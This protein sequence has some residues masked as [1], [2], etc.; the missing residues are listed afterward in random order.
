MDK[1]AVRNQE[2]IELWQ[3]PQEVK[4]IVAPKLNNTEFGFFMALSKALG[5]NP[6]KREIWAI[7]YGTEPA[8]VFCGRDF[9]RRKAQEQK[10]YKGHVVECI[11]KN[12]EFA[13]KREINLSTGETKIS[14]VIHNYGIDRGEL[15]GAY[16]IVFREGKSPTYVN[17]PLAEFQ[18][19]KKGGEITTMWKTKAETQIKKVAES[20]TLRM[21]YQDVFGGTYDESEKW[22]GKTIDI[23]PGE[24]EPAYKT[25]KLAT[26]P[27][28]DL[29]RNIVKS[30]VF[31]EQERDTI[32]AKAADALLTVKEFEKGKKWLQDTS[33][34]RKD[35][36]KAAKAE[37]APAQEFGEEEA[38]KGLQV[39][40]AQYGEQS[41]EAMDYASA[42]QAEDYDIL[43]K[44]VGAAEN[45]AKN[46]PEKMA[47]SEIPNGGIPA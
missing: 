1:L 42:W 30:H 33:K 25:E 20:L 2:V 35:A 24:K 19:R 10:D 18:Q 8:Q 39:V 40:S 9:Y 5:A 32:L 34:Y 22:E 3:N 31:T 13:V 37:A 45:A 7:K 29:M 27:Q 11:R 46:M 26:G 6:F 23:S 17:V 15:L 38:M 28:K 16:C 14:E 44:M 21:A 43:Q 36:E 41:D 47:P 4:A 12:D